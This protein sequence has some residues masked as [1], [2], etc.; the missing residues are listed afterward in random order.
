MKDL[1][2]FY[3]TIAGIDFTLLGL[4]WVAVQELRHLR[5]PN[6]KAG[7]MAYV[8]SLQFLVP[9][10][11]ALMSQVAPEVAF[12]WRLAFTTAGV[13]GAAAIILLAPRLLNGGSSTAGRSLVAVGGPLY[14]LVAVVAAVPQVE[15][16]IGTSLNGAQWEGLLFCLL[17]L[18]S[19]H[20]AWT[21]AM[22][23]PIDAD[24]E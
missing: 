17:V 6:G 3:S 22:S 15:N 24:E 2:D 1:S 5:A 4:W 7:A 12:L 23:K 13:L 8:V 18:V 9:G 10:T 19:A 11:A 14:A 21:A 16:A 20:T